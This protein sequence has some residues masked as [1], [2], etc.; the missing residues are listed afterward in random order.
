[1]PSGLSASESLCPHSV[2]KA[3]LLD[4]DDKMKD[5][6]RVQNGVE[7]EEEQSVLERNWIRP[8]LASRCTWQLGG[9]NTDS[10]HVHA[11]W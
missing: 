8:D 10:P 3:S 4:G 2:G 11:E 9:P 7:E 6:T 5:K 1:M